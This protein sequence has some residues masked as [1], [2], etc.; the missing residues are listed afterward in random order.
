M[1]TK[2]SLKNLSDKQLSKLLN[3]HAVRVQHGTGMSVHMSPEQHK[4]LMKASKNDKGMTLRFD[5]YQ[6]L[7]HGY[8]RAS[9][10]GRNAK[11][12]IGGN[13]TATSKDAGKEARV[14]LRQVLR[15][16]REVILEALYRTARIGRP[17]SMFKLSTRWIQSSLSKR[18][19]YTAL[20][21]NIF[22]A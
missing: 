10:I 5:P 3:G 8:L 4:K 15:T 6:M 20:R 13:I 16:A 11:K 12:L 22:D 2:V 9:G 1:Y 7:N 19:P 21:V 17:H 18:R 14:F